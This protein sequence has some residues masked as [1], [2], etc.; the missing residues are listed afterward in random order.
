MVGKP[1]FIS[2]THPLRSDKMRKTLI[3]IVLFQIG[4]F[5]CVLGAAADKALIGAS[6]ALAII[7]FHLIRTTEW[8]NELMLILIAMFI[9]FIWDSYLVYRGWIQYPYGQLTADTAPY[10]IVIMWGLFATTLNISLS[11]LK[12][13]LVASI[14]FGVVGG[15]LA[16]IA[17]NKLGAVD[18]PD[19]VS[20]LIALSIG[21]GIL[22]PLLLKLPGFINGSNKD[23]IRSES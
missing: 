10:W 6:V 12:Q 18:F 5:A 2:K 17:G 23:T 14:L 19:S 15:P 7:L 11:W 22:T 4:W 1:L 21:W 13:R 8:R 16:Y 20:A 9:G 3:N